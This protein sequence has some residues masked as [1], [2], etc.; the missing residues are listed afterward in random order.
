MIT[1]GRNF[2]NRMIFE[3]VARYWKNTVDVE[4]SV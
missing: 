3:L 1:Q 2:E 4:H